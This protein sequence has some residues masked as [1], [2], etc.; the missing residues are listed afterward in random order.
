MILDSSVVVAVCLG[1][2]DASALHDVLETT[3]TVKISS[4]TYLESAM[5][6]D[7]RRPGALERFT[8]NMEL[9]VVPF[10]QEQADIARNAYR[11][12]GKGSGHPAR[13]NLGDCF[14][15]ALAK[16]TGEILFFKGNDF[17]QTDVESLQV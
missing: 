13:L 10:D 2:P 3:E 8:T 6:I 11:R 15:Y 14:S 4:A 17:S 12:Y 5:V 1:E 7:A 9:T 16:V